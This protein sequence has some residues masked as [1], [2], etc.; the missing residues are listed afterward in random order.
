M[1]C[2]FTV[3]VVVA[4]MV[5]TI[6]I[7]SANHALSIVHP[8]LKAKTLAEGSKKA[9]SKAFRSAGNSFR[10]F[11]TSNNPCFFFFIFTIDGCCFPEFI[12]P[13][14][15]RPKT[16][17]AVAQRMVTRALGLQKRGRVQ[18]YWGNSLTPDLNKNLFILYMKHESHNVW[19]PKIVI[20]L[21]I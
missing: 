12:Q 5:K 19:H 4:V 20:Y 15:E 14:K 9:K 2:C 13:V 21:K 8:M 7:S 1:R 6:L 18:R 16:D 17:C 11:Q 3:N 10:S